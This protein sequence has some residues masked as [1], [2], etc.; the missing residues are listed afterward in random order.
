M[1]RWN[2]PPKGR[3]FVGFPPGVQQ[4]HGLEH[5]ARSVELSPAVGLE[6][7]CPSAIVV[8]HVRYASVPDDPSSLEQDGAS[9]ERLDGRHV[10]ADEQ[11][12][13]PR[14][15]DLLHP[16]QAFPL[17]SQVADS[18]HLVDDQDLRLGGAPATANANLTYIPLE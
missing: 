18:Q 4:H 11:N 1:R 3:K 15:P 8:D 9:A 2:A 16:P 5:A 13:A 7:H 17:E 6:G 12:G 10:V 14:P